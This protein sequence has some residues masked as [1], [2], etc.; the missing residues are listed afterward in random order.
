MLVTPTDQLHFVQLPGRS[1]ADPFPGAG[2][3]L[4]VRIVRMSHDPG[5]RPHRHPHSYELVHVLRGEGHAWS[6]GTLTPVRAG[7]TFLVPTGL[8]HA[9]LPAPGSH[10]ELLCFFPHPDL[11]ANIEE[12]DAPV[13]G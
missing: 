2:L 11:R 1:S 3:P 13:L 9:T 10:L 8:P 12:L 4:S 7:A 6:D 5:R